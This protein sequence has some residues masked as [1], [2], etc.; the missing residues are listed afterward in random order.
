MEEVNH[1][2]LVRSVESDNEYQVNSKMIY[3]NVHVQ[4]GGNI[5]GH[6]SICWSVMMNMPNKDWNT[7]PEYLKATP[8][9]NIDFG[10]RKP[11][12]TE[13]L[14]VKHASSSMKYECQQDS[15]ACRDNTVE[16]S[17][18]KAQNFK[19]DSG[20]GVQCYKCKIVTNNR[21]LGSYPFE[22]HCRISPKCSH[23][24]MK[25]STISLVEGANIYASS[26]RTDIDIERTYFDPSDISDYTVVI[27]DNSCSQ[28]LQFDE[29]CSYVHLWQKLGYEDAREPS[30]T[31]KDAYPVSNVDTFHR[32]K[33]TCLHRNQTTCEKVSLPMERSNTTVHGQIN[34]S[35]INHSNLKTKNNDNL[36][37]FNQSNPQYHVQYF[38]MRSAPLRRIKKIQ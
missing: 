14:I 37:T 28:K 1:D 26:Q 4:I 25:E 27:S 18:S 29:S 31:E 5:T 30:T 2:M 12:R 24:K 17:S 34:Q 20:V 19:D 16:N 11:N 32:H 35:S 13:T 8:H 38:K 33:K 6:V 22:E 9:F 3:Q 15:T 23:V 36:F 10:L 7:L 21:N